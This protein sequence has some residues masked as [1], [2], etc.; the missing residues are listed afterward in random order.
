[1]ASFCR[2]CNHRKADSGLGGL[3]LVFSFWSLCL[4]SNGADTLP[5][6]SLFIVQPMRLRACQRRPVHSTPACLALCSTSLHGSFPSHTAWRLLVLH[7]CAPPLC[8]LLLDL[9]IGSCPRESPIG[10]STRRRVV[11]FRAFLEVLC[12]Q[13]GG[14]VVNRPLGHHAQ[15]WTLLPFSLPLALS[16]QSGPNVTKPGYLS[17]FTRSSYEVWSASLW[18]EMGMLIMLS[19]DILRTP[20]FRSTTILFFPFFPFFLRYFRYI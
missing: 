7:G 1:M 18:S 14:F 16:G 3:S 9:A 11:Y 8:C 17:I 15:L 19:F 5:S 4:F 6:L 2:Y 10:P 20:P 13:S 12:H